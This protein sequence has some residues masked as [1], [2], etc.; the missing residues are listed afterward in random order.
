MCNTRGR[1]LPQAGLLRSPPAAALLAAFRDPGLRLTR[2]H[3][4]PNLTTP[5]KITHRAGSGVA[6]TRWHLPP[7]LRLGPFERQS[8]GPHRT[9]V[10]A[11]PHRVCVR[12][13]RQ[14]LDPLASPLHTQTCHWW[15]WLC[16]LR[17]EVTSR[18]PW[19]ALWRAANGGLTMTRSVKDGT[20]CLAEVS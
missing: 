9:V 6:V 10:R 7:I 13:V 17:S 3:P 4:G 15:P 19:C 8:A 11:S 2:I 18:T 5:G 14:G 16:E 12:R 1:A 20:R